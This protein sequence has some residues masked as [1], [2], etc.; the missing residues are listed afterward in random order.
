VVRDFT[1][2]ISDVCDCLVELEEEEGCA[3]QRETGAEG[4][5]TS[6]RTTYFIFLVGWKV[7]DINSIDGSMFIASS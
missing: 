7:G 5:N 1:F 4:L 2:R 6:L 3:A